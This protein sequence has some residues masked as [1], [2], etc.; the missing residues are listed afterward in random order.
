MRRDLLS[1]L[2]REPLV[3]FV[4][5]GVLVFGVHRL[6]SPAAGGRIEVSAETVA[7]LRLEHERRRGAPASLEEQ[8]ALIERHVENELLVREALALGLD[9]GDIIV[10]RR[11]IQ[12][13]QLLLEG[14]PADAPGEAELRACFERDRE[15]WRRPATVSFEHVF[16][17]AGEDDAG[18]A[19][20]A[21][22]ALASG[23][24]PGG[25]GDPFVR[26]H[27]LE[28]LTDTEVAASFGGGFAAAL[29]T[30]APGGWS[31]PLR[32]PYGLHLVRVTARVPARPATWDEVAT[33]ARQECARAWR[34]ARIRRA[35]D[36]LRARHD[37][38][39]SPEAL[40]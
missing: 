38:H 5:A 13:M 25:L 26:G 10:R 11:L 15:R 17:R 19:R 35:I 31:P 14:D 24:D 23:A 22:E 39:V 2:V 30:L 6:L 32:S 9:R 1:A 12:K 29:E 37:V 18:R 27:T 28:G 40:L 8:R 34:E 20:A 33:Q 4:L 21:A 36:E 16:V 3:H 7:G